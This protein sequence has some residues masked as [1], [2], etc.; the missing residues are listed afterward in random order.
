MGVA[1]LLL[2]MAA[3][4]N[5]IGISGSNKRGERKSND[6][7]NYEFRTSDEFE[8]TNGDE[9]EMLD[10]D[11]GGMSGIEITNI[12]GETFSVKEEIGSAVVNP[13]EI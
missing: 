10:L 2:T 3:A 11:A 6:T 8:K 5:S 13:D 4:I 7:F 12:D 1:S 9:F